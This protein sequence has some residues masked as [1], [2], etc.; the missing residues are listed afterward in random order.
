MQ[1]QNS[2][3]NPFWINEFNT[4]TW[5]A[6][7]WNQRKSGKFTKE[8]EKFQPWKVTT[9]ICRSILIRNFFAPHLKNA[10]VFAKL[11]K[12]MNSGAKTGVLF[13]T[14]EGVYKFDLESVFRLTK[15]VHMVRWKK[16]RAIQFIIE[17]SFCELTWKFVM[18]ISHTN[19]DYLILSYQIATVH[20][21]YLSVS[22]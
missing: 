7:M 18:L 12:N 14:I 13:K 20:R 21:Y 1:T 22:S 2:E 5:V 6:W 15:Y 4:N 17:F 10:S 11:A 19:D 3:W 9:Y 16:I 8:T